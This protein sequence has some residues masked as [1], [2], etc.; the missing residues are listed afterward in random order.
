MIDNGNTRLIIEL[1]GQLRAEQ[2]DG[3]DCGV[4]EDVLR[5]DNTNL[6]ND[7]TSPAAAAVP[8]RCFPSGSFRNKDISAWCKTIALRSRRAA[9]G[10]QQ[11]QEQLLRELQK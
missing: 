4:R 2:C 1:A 11:Q 3:R 6:D 9:V 8:W 10:A 7:P 5:H